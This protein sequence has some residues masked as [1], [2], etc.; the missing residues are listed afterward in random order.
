MGSLS[1]RSLLH[2][3]MALSTPVLIA[4]GIKSAYLSR[5]LMDLSPEKSAEAKAALSVDLDT[6]LSV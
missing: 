6:S 1:E 3:V 4:V 5:S 2:F